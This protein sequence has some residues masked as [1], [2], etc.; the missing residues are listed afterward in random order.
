MIG[1]IFGHVLLVSW[2]T[3]ISLIIGMSLMIYLFLNHK[4][5]FNDI[6]RGIERFIDGLFDSLRDD[7]MQSWNS[8]LDID[9][10]AV[11]IFYVTMGRLIWTVVEVVLIRAGLGAIFVKRDPGLTEV[12]APDKV[13]VTRP[14]DAPTNR[15]A[16]KEGPEIR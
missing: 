2:R 6:D 5:L 14:G 1:R 16:P 4:G 15:L 11:G 12:V 3:V 13:D 8:L 10:M 7:N 9:T